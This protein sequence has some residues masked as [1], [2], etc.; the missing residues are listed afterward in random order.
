MASTKGG[1]MLILE[2]SDP[3]AARSIWLV[4][5]NPGS[6]LVTVADVSKR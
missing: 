1:G 4:E 6:D 5:Q 3:S 2:I